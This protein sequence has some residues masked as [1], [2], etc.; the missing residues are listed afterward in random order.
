MA[1]AG[2]EDLREVIGCTPRVPDGFEQAH[3]RSHHLVAEGRSGD[4]DCDTVF[5]LHVHVHVE[6]TA[7][8][9][10]GSPRLAE[11]REVVLTEET[12]CRGPHAVRVQP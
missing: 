4:P 8:R 2:C 1:I 11:G 10:A 5:G 9:P 3:D 6:D 12:P 7:Y